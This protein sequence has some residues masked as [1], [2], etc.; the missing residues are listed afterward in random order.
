MNNLLDF[1]DILVL[2][3]LRILIVR[4]DNMICFGK[5][6]LWF[7]DLVGMK[8]IVFIGWEIIYVF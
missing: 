2:F 1:S 6:N 8:W 5:E 4:F 7:S 3:G